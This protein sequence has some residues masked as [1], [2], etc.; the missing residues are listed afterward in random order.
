MKILQLQKEN[1]ALRERLDKAVE[2]KEPYLEFEPYGGMCIVHY[3]K[4]I[5]KDEAYDDRAAVEKRL[6]ELGGEK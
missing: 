3:E 1:A 5:Y 2:L 6:A 4:V